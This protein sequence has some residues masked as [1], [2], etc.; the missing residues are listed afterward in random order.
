MAAIPE[1]PALTEAPSFTRKAV[2][3]MLAAPPF[4]HQE[5]WNT[6]ATY[7]GPMVSGAPAGHAPDRRMDAF[8]QIRDLTRGQT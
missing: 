2:A 7:E 1:R 3:R 6:L 8:P 5:E 4:F